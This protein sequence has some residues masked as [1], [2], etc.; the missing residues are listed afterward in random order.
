MFL[1]IPHL[2]YSTFPLEDIWL[3]VTHITE[4]VLKF[5]FFLKAYS[6]FIT[7]EERKLLLEFSSFNS[8]YNADANLSA[9]IIYFAPFLSQVEF[10]DKL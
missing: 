4:A 5:F 6:N 3:Y 9:I 7:K 10:H 8:L 1:N 2:L